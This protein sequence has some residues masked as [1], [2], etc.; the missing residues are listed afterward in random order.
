MTAARRA[1]IYRILCAAAPLAAVY[2]IVSE[3]EL[4]LW[5]GLAAAILGNG[6]AAVNTPTKRGDHA[7]D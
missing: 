4:P 6:L 3:S 1:W 5:L 7:A 2:G